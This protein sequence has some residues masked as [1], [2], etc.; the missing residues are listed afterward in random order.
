M[1][2]ET[3]P[4]SNKLADAEEE[5]EAAAPRAGFFGA[6]VLTG[7]GGNTTGTLVD[8]CAFIDPADGLDE[9]AV[10]A[11]TGGREL[12]LV[13]A[14]DESPEEPRD[15]PVLL[16][17]LTQFQ[18]LYYKVPTYLWLEEQTDQ[19]HRKDQSTA[20]PE[21]QKTPHQNLDW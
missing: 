18:L 6:K 19:K 12:F 14:K 4:K 20:L 7:G 10:A 1:L 13:G 17:T 21:L 11:A 3:S 2:V 5:A 15:G 8:D 9:V 16:I